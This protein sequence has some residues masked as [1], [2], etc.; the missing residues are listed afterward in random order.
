MNLKTPAMRFCLDKKIVLKI[1][2]FENVHC[3]VFKFLRRI[4]DGKHLMSFQSEKSAF[5]FQRVIWT[6]N[7]WAVFKMKLR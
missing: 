7:T 1:K 5:K 4:V 3:C 6:K 2:L